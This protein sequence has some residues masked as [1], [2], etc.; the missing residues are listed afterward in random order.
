MQSLSKSQWNFCTEI[1][2]TIQKLMCNRER[3]GTIK[4][5]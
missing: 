5:T 1:G 2:K 3:P 4:A